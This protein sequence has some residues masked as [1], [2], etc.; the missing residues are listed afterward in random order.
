MHGPSVT[1]I[2]DERLVALIERATYRVVLLAPGVS[3]P[4]ARV[5][6]AA[7]Y[8]LGADAVTVILD[9]DPEVCRLGYGTL[10]ALQILRDAAAKVGALV[11]RQPGLRIGVII[12]DDSTVIYSP[13]PLLI[14]AGSDQPERPNAIQLD[15]QNRS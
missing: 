14:E 3:E 9:I 11:C 2:D 6:T 5:L 10:E 15:R 1:N 8:R 12:S 7:W 13:T 4:V